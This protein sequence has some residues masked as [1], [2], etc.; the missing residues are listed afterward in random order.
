MLDIAHDPDD[1]G[2]LRSRRQ[3]DLTADWLLECE[4]PFNQRLADHNAWRGRRIVARLEGPARHNGY[5]HRVE[6]GRARFAHHSLAS[7]IIR[8]YADETASAVPRQRNFVDDGY[9]AG[10]KTV[11]QG[12]L[13]RR[14]KRH[15]SFEVVARRW[16]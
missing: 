12:A 2:H 1:F 16:H 8:P 5:P 3:P 7:D 14:V 10:S 15:H 6:I 11:F 13:K 9:R 4:Q